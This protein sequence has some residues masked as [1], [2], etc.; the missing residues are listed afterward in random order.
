MLEFTAL[1]DGQISTHALREEGDPVA[2]RKGVE[3]RISTH[4]LREEGDAIDASSSHADAISTHALREEGDRPVRP[5]RWPGAY[6]YPRPPRGGRPLWTSAATQSL[7]ISTH[8]LR[9]EGDPAR[10]TDA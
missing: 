3:Q 5:P 6:F 10:M 7:K 8:A 4:A 2:K 1:T 9:E